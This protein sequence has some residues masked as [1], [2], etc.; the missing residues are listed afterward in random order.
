MIPAEIRFTQGTTDIGTANFIL[1]VEKTPHAEG[2][3]DG[4]QETMANLETRLQAEID[5]L[6]DRVTTLENGGGGGSGGITV[7]SLASEMTD[8][9]SVYLYN[10][11]EIGYT[12]GHWYFYN[13]SNS[14]WTDGGEYTGWETVNTALETFLEEN[15]Q[16]MGVLTVTVGDTTYRYNGASNIAITLPIY[17]GGVS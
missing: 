17:D 9:S 2:T 6:D 14:A 5:G 4:T 13:T 10:G 16:E 11:T 1:A 8:R 7:V 3:T 12:A 15:A